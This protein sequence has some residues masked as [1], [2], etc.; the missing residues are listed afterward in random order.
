MSPEITVLR[1]SQQA[2]E[3]MIKLKRVTGIKQWNVLCRWALCVSLA[4]PSPPLV[5]EVI[6]DSNVE[7]SWR[8]LVGG[9]DS[10]FAGLIK[11]R[12]RQDGFASTQQTLVVHVHRGLGHLAGGLSR[13][14]RIEDFV[15]AGTTT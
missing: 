9:H 11:H 1:V 3:Q 14:G 12:Q 5:R 15:A 7:M 10:T 2:K 6:A 4:D 8:T 13:D